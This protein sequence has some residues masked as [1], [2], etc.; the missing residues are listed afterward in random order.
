MSL[1]VAQT[2]LYFKGYTTPSVL[3]TFGCFSLDKQL[4]MMSLYRNV[5][6]DVK[7]CFSLKNKIDNFGLNEPLFY[8]SFFFFFAMFAYLISLLKH[9]LARV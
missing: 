5:I 9:L 2:L 4:F 3:R 6:V 8:N 7:F 1:K